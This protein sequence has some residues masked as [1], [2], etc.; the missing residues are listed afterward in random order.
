MVHHVWRG[1]SLILKLQ[2]TSTPMSILNTMLSMLCQPF[3][4]K[5]VIHE[6]SASM[7]PLW[8]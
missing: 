1:I 7:K 8:N 2:K 4:S 5:S 3:N 6:A